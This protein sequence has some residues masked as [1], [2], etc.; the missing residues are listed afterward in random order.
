[1]DMPEWKARALFEAWR[2]HYDLP[3]T[4]EVERLVYT[5]EKWP[6]AVEADLHMHANGTDL[7]EMWRTRRW[8][9]LLLLIDHLPG[10]SYTAAATANDEEHA[11]R[12]AE[13]LA[14][15]ENDDDK[16]DL[17]PPIH[18]WTPE[19]AAIADLI[20]AVNAGFHKNFAAQ[21]G[22]SSKAGPPPTPY[23]TPKTAFGRARERARYERRMRQHE[24][25]ARRLLPHK[26]G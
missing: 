22:G 23:P 25:L 1:M 15:H 11:T 8:R 21:V 18:R 24:S 3:T 5:I 4:Q 20:N 2:L 9:R 19:V 13:Y 12:L 16:E 26:Y 10:H 7:G 17:G 14:E 6:R